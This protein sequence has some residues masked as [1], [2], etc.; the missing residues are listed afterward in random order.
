MWQV[1]TTERFDVW[2]SIQP[3]PLQ[4]EILAV[5]RILSEFGPQLG[6]PYVDTI[7]GSTY[8][9]YER[10]EDPVCRFSRTR[11]FCV[12]FYAVGYCVV[13]RR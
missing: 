4:D 11:F 6:R 3:E 12:R 8:S 5:F 2:F 7:K 1:I 10:V 9:N 13:R